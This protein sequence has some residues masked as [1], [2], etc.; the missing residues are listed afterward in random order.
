MRG[1]KAVVAAGADSGG[2]PGVS[3]FAKYR[4]REKKSYKTPTFIARS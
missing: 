2:P 4:T 1:H 3:P